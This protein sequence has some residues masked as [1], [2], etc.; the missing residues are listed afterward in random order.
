M[1]LK[2][3]HIARPV[4]EFDA[5]VVGSGITGGFAAKE[6]TE[7]GLK[8]VL[9]ERGRNVEHS[10]DYVTEH[11]A[12]WEFEFRGA[13]DRKK[14]MAEYPV[15]SRSGPVQE[16]N[17]HW[18]VKDTEHPYV[19]VKPFTWVRG[20]H[21][22]GRSLTW[23]RHCY[24]WSDLD[25]EANQRDGVAVDWPIRYGDIAP[26]Y[27][28]VD[29]WVGIEGEALGLSQL[30]DSKFLPPMPL[31]VGERVVREAVEK[32]FPGRNVTIGRTAI[33]TQPHRGRAACHYCGPCARGCSAGAYFSSQSS[34]LPAARATGNLTIRTNSIV[35]SVVYDPEAGRAVGVRVIDAQTLEQTEYRARV[36]FL[37]ASALGS[38]QILLNSTSSSFPNGLANSSGT[39]GHYLM[40]HHFEV[41]AR[42]EIPGLLDRYYRGN[43][44]TGIYIPRFQNLDRRTRRSDFIRGYGYQGDA[45]RDGWN[46]DSQG[47][48]TA[49]K[50][51]LREPGPWIMSINAFGEMLPRYENFVEL[52]NEKKDKWGIPLL[53]IDCALGENEFAMR[54]DMMTS[55]VEMLEAAGCK[56][57]RPYERSD[58]SPGLGIHEMGTARMGRDP[59]SSVLNEWNQA[60]DVKNLYVTDGA[61]MTSSACQNPSYTYMALTA[62]A[63]DHAVQELKKLNL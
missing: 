28:Y 62:R 44:P 42:G 49:L 17:V 8:T 3:V 4:N 54:K 41:G 10:T 51:E 9:I 53:R 7:K 47:F 12:R 21:L 2:N 55:A 1:P 43:R 18:F 34:T 13:G 57:I 5:I 29:D 23:G 33:L 24:R 27:D 30:P 15:Q 35:H 38:T 60:H 56:N 50:K 6:L 14:R 48:G 52:D 61:C 45:R 11:K 39:L 31:N 46:R 40:D 25:F 16:D 58:F 32:S 20:Y 63:A 26:W 22:G 37:C 36:I 59:K 19:E